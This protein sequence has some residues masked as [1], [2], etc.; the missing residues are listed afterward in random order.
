MTLML[1]S[2]KAANRVAAAAG[3]LHSTPK[4]KPSTSS[5]RSSRNETGKLGRTAIRR[6]LSVCAAS[7]HPVETGEGETPSILASPY[8]GKTAIVVG[9]GPAGTVAGIQLARRGFNVKVVEKRPKPSKVD[10]HRSI[11]FMLNPEVSEFLLELG[12]DVATHPSEEGLTEFVDATRIME[13]GEILHVSGVPKRQF[14]NERHVVAESILKLGM[15]P[16]LPNLEF[17]FDSECM[18]IDIDSKVV[19]FSTLDGETVNDFHYDLL[20]G[21]DGVNSRVREALQSS[22]HL[23]F[24]QRKAAK[25]YL[26]V[27][28]LPFPKEAPSEFSDRLQV[29]SF[30]LML[31]KEVENGPT[32]M[33]IY[34]TKN[35]LVQ[36][37]AAGD[38][39]CFDSIKGREL[40]WITKAVPDCFPKDFLQPI[41]ERLHDSKPSRTGPVTYCSSYIGPNEA[42]IGDSCHSVTPT[43]GIGANLAILDGRDLG[44]AF[45][46]P[47]GNISEALQKY[48][49]QCRPQ[50]KALQELEG[51]QPNAG[52]EGQNPIWSLFIPLYTSFHLFGN[53]KFPNIVPRSA[54]AQMISSTVT[55]VEALQ[56]FKRSVAIWAGIAGVLGVLGFSATLQV[57]L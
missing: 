13:N 19:K 57:L 1:G 23:E 49:E 8:E 43:F 18:N 39:G 15:S 31:L 4:R 54:T 30:T 6:R 12:V 55:P 25:Q 45:G 37:S 33:Y 53:K 26:S 17:I 38:F 46:S 29:G 9:A 5:R 24:T 48:D 28:D 21:A 52:L 32:A 7:T 35:G 11:V 42:L 44:K 34:Q 56:I 36:A 2:G 51:F 27:R 14:L 47:N 16:A 20:V 50:V 40:E 10:I 22:G 3:Y 41:A